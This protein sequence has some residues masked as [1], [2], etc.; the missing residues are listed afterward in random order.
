MPD[1]PSFQSGIHASWADFRDFL[2]SVRFAHRELLWFTLQPAILTI[3]GFFAGRR[4]RRDAAKIGQ[5]GAL[6][7]L[8]T[9]RRRPSRL[10]GLALFLAWTLLVIGAAGPR[11]GPGGD[12]G[13]AVGRDVVVVIDLS[14][15]MLANDAAPVGGSNER[16]KSAV[17]AAKNLVETL[18]TRGGHRAGI[19]IFAGRSRILAPLT[20]DYDHL[21]AKLDEINL[22]H[23]IPELRPANDTA[24]SGTRIGAAIQQAVE[25][26]DPNFQGY[27]DIL[28]ISDGD[29]PGNDSEWAVGVSAARKAEIPVHTIGVGTAKLTDLPFHV[30]G[31]KGDPIPGQSQLREDVLKEIASGTRGLY[32]PPTTSHPPFLGEFFR[33]K[34]EPNPSRIL[35]D[36]VLPQ[37]RDRSVWFLAIGLVF[38]IVGWLRER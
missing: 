22:D 27:Q 26:H 35:S 23:P 9:G 6:A 38:L 29:D 30:E 34:I 25:V 20:T 2:A 16:W 14:R 8:L 15:S 1:L 4:A 10:G 24:V 3:V 19:V 17:A 12:P 31:P 32:L 7:S 28:L 21:L 18:Q 36:D 11:W 13:V 33:T 37:P 5:P